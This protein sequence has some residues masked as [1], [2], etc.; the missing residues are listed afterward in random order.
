MAINPWILLA[1]LVCLLSRVVGLRVGS[2]DSE[3]QSPLLIT[4]P[5]AKYQGYFN[6]TSSLNTW[7]GIR[8]AASPTGSNRW[9][10]PQAPEV[11]SPGSLPLVEANSLPKQCPQNVVRKIRYIPTRIVVLMAV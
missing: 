7:L 1:F 11:T 4:L 2:R 9:R 8:Y 5:Y 10:A 3:S 6:E